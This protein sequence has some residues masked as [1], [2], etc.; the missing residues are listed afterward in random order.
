VDYAAVVDSGSLQPVNLLRGEILVAV[1]VRF[2]ATRL[3]DNI[4]VTAD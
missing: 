4:T 2:G 3:I 1:A